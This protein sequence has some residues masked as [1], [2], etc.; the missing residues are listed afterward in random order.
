VA[1]SALDVTIDD[2]EVYA[3]IERLIKRIDNP[4]PLLQTVGRY[5]R[6][7]TKKMFTG[8]RPDTQGVRGEK[9]DKLAESTLA[10]KKQLRAKG[11]SI[12]N[13]ARPLVRTGMLKD[14]LLSKRAI[15][16]KGKGLEYGT[17]RKSNMGFP[18]PAIHQVGGRILPARRWLFLRREELMQ[19]AQTTREYLM[20]MLKELRA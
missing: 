20:G 9:W 11:Q 16:I 10:H 6:V 14:D 13:P 18:S 12:G 4:A 8:A 7:L 1:K 5:I 19:I 17:D 2:R 15:K 3:M